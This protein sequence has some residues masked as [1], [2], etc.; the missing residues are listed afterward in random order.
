MRPIVVCIFFFSLLILVLINRLCIE[1]SSRKG[2][3]IN[4]MQNWST[5]LIF[6][7][8]KGCFIIFIITTRLL[9]LL[10]VLVFACAR[11]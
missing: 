9:F 5:R 6:H 10:C 1:S 7:P 4:K 3:V 2:F 8:T 11:V